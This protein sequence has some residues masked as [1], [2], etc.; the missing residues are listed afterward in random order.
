MA[1][2]VMSFLRMMTSTKH[3]VAEKI[4]D[5]RSSTKYSGQSKCKGDE[6][7]VEGSSS[8]VKKL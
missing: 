6:V 3:Q 7:V 5:G 1:S 8:C 4:S 2:Q